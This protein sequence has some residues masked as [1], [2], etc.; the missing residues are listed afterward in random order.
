MED[1]NRDSVM[2]L[3]LYCIENT[4]RVPEA[5]LKNNSQPSYKFFRTTCFIL[6]NSLYGTIYRNTNNKA[7]KNL[8]FR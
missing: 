3:S 6:G 7:F 5:Q 4:A 1:K 8:E 2:F